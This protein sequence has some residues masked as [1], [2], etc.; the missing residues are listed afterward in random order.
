MAI[1]KLLRA[2][3]FQMLNKFRPTCFLARGRGRTF[4]ETGLHIMVYHMVYTIHWYIPILVYTN[5]GI[6]QYWYILWYITCAKVYSYYVILYGIYH[7]KLNYDITW[8][9]PP[10]VYTTIY[11]YHGISLTKFQYIPYH[12]TW[13]IPCYIAFMCFLIT[14]DIPCDITSPM[15]SYHMV[16]HTSLNRYHNRYHKGGIYQPV[17][18]IP[19][20][21]T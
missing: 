16:Y 15:L 10:L 18:Y 20:D 9:I 5:I 19:C 14:C 4:L 2:W 17:W 7:V 8:Y 3:C 12:I 21:I 11:I 13:Y 1:P 6:Y